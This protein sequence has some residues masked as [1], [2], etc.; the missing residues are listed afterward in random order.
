VA[1]RRPHGTLLHRLPLLHH[2]RRNQ[3]LARK[4]LL[5]VDDLCGFELAVCAVASCE[6]PREVDQCAEEEERDEDE[7]ED[8]EDGESVAVVLLD[9]LFGSGCWPSGW[10]TGPGAG[11][12]GR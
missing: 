4:P 5:Q 3:L 6:A 8:H 11:G 2:R 9:G 10:K 1:G 12:S 7:A